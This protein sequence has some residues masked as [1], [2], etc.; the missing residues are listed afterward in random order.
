M[1]CPGV[2]GPFY[3]KLDAVVYFFNQSQREVYGYLINYDIQLLKY[4]IYLMK[5]DITLQNLNSRYKVQVRAV[6]GQLDFQPEI[7]GE[8]SGTELVSG[9]TEHVKAGRQ[10]FGH[11]FLAIIEVIRPVSERRR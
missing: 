2:S 5:Y 7:A 9:A 1:N 11:K 3:L 4:N 10:D 6:A 8:P